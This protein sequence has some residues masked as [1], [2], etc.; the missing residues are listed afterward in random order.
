MKDLYEILEVSPKASEEVIEKAYKVLAKKYHPDLQSN[1]AQKKLCEQKM[2][3]LNEAYE[4]LGDKEKRKQYDAQR[5]EK[6]E[7]KEPHTNEP[8]KKTQT[9]YT[10]SP[11]PKTEQPESIYDIYGQVKYYRDTLKR[12]AERQEKMHAQEQ[13][14]YQYAY[15][16]YLKS[17]GFKVKKKWTWRRV[18]DLLKALGIM[19]SIILALWLFPPTRNGMISFY[20]NNVIIKA[21]VDFIGNFFHALFRRMQ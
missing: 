6:E 17:L 2:K 15:E 18:K 1:E 13:S 10:E 4:I 14:A 12:Q 11:P 7:T 21:L 3:V 5:K 16:K 20:E 9:T 8:P 19:A